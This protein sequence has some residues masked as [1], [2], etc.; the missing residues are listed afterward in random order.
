MLGWQHGMEGPNLRNVPKIPP[1]L[2]PKSQRQFLRRQLLH[3]P[4][5]CQSPGAQ[6][7][8]GPRRGPTAA[9]Q[10]STS[11]FTEPAGSQPHLTA[12]NVLLKHGSL[13]VLLP[14]CSPSDSH[15]SSPLS[16]LMT[17]L[18]TPSLCLWPM[19]LAELQM[20]PRCLGDVGACEASGRAGAWAGPPCCRQCT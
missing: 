15:T 5:R 17:S 18:V 12:W 20:S 3:C 8:P 10:V 11:Q 1:G 6:G 13:S 16:A 14:S 2:P 4:L 7:V 19:C 9:S